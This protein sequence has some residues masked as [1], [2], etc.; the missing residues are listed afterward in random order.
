MHIETRAKNRIVERNVRQGW[1]DPPILEA[2]AQRVEGALSDMY[3]HRH[4]RRAQRESA[5]A[6][7]R[8]PG[9]AGN[10][11]FRSGQQARQTQHQYGLRFNDP[12][13]LCPDFGE[14]A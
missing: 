9:V 8:S 14:G 7:K 5:H 11:P 10:P 6:C 2:N 1:R 13:R 4:S 12:H 3:F